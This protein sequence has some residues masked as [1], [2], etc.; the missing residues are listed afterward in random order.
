MLGCSP[1]YGTAVD[2]VVVH[3]PEVGTARV[4]AGVCH[5]LWAGRCG[6]S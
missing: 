2:G 1:V 3:S 5:R 6:W 4:L